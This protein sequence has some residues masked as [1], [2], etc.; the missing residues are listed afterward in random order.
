MKW[1]AVSRREPDNYWRGGPAR[2][3]IPYMLYDRRVPAVDP[4]QDLATVVAQRIRSIERADPQRERKALRVFLETM[5]LAELGQQLAADPSFTQMV[6][7]VQAQMESDP[8]LAEAARDAA[9]VL[10]KNA[11]T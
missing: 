5:L 4:A 8:D 3:E 1:K 11:D 6:D 10:L 2:R 9:Q 7:H